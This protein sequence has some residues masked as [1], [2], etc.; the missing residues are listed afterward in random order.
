MSHSENTSS[1]K[2]SILDSAKQII[3]GDREKAYGSPDKNLA[4]IASYWEKHLQA[5]NGTTKLHI[6]VNDVCIMMALM[7]LA[8]LVNTPSHK[9]SQVDVCGY[10]A[11]MERCQEAYKESLVADTAGKKEVPKEVKPVV[12]SRPYDTEVIPK[13]PDDLGIELDFLKLD[14]KLGNYP[15]S[16]TES[17][18]EIV[19]KYYEKY[20]S[21]TQQ[22]IKEMKETDTKHP[23]PE[24]VDPNRNKPITK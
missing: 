6:G 17:Q 16:F 1:Y 14:N 23:Y 3:Y 24:S 18:A 20:G 22:T 4:L 21:L 2:Q 19:R 8:R 5:V 13:Y 10:M 11:L 7:K 15:M 12:P 9:D